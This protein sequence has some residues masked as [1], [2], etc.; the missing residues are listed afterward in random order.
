VFVSPA[1][2][3]RGLAGFGP[4]RDTFD[5][6]GVDAAGFGEQVERGVEDGLLDSSVARPAAL[7]DW[8][9]AR[10]A[11][12]EVLSVRRLASYDWRLW[13]GCAPVARRRLTALCR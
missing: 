5:R 9:A 6:D 8:Q 13:W 4:G 1:S 12:A 2:V 7:G 3:D 11:G 10:L